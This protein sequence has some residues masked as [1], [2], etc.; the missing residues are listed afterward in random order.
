MRLYERDVRFRLPFRF[1]VATLT[2]APQAFAR[3]RIETPAGNGARGSAAEV[4]APKWFDK[5]P[6]LSNEDNVEQLRASLRLAA[7]AYQAHGTETAFGIAAACYRGQLAAG[8][9]GVRA[10]REHRRR[11]LR[12]EDHPTASAAGRRL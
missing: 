6:G 9:V 11:F 8:D 3:V 5:R 12:G 1:G 2:E 4:L 10:Q 7:A